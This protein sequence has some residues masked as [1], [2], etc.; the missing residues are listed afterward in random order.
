M[1]SNKQETEE[2][3][4][5][6]QKLTRFVQREGIHLTFMI[7]LVLI[8]TTSDVFLAILGQQNRR[9]TWFP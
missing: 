8:I 2:P 3:H 9:K 4:G 6:R 1:K 5:H 7:F